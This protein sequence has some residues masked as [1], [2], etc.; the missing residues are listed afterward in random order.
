VFR[1]VDERRKRGEFTRDTAENAIS[2]LMTFAD[3]VGRRRLEQ[4]GPRDVERWLETRGHLARSTRRNQFSKVAH[5]CRWLRRRGL[6]RQDIA[7]DVESPKQPR[8]VPR[9]LS[10]EAVAKL[11]AVMPDHRARVLF[12]LGYGL[13][14]RCIEMAR[15]ELTDWD[16]TAGIMIVCGKGSHER[17]VP[18]EPRQAVWALDAYLDEHPVAGGPLIRS[19]NAPHRALTE[20]TISRLGTE[21]MYAAGI[22]RRNRDG[23]SWHALRHTA[24]TELLEASGGDLRVVQEF[25]GHQHLSSTSIYLARAGAK[26]IRAA[27]QLRTFGDARV[28]AGGQLLQLPGLDVDEPVPGRDDGPRRSGGHHAEEHDETHP[29]ARN[30]ERRRQGSDVA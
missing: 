20:Q 25:L 22:K 16:R 21:W 6:T 17:F 19:Y 13:G 18:V 3:V 5:F 4:L 9:A 29:G 30:R 24:A 23:V 27:M 10:P 26:K 11:L 28:V 2:T 7:E 8:S 14:L 12:W 1:Y 15:L